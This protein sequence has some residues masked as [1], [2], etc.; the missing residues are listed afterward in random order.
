MD[1]I[2]KIQTIIANL[3]TLI[4]DMKFWGAKRAEAE[5]DYHKC[6][7]KETMKERDKGTAVGIITLTIKGNE[8]VADKRFERDYAE[9]M[10]NATQELINISKLDARMTEAQ[11]QR[12]WG[13]KE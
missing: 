8:E 4:D 5:R 7:S 9:V 1:L 6:L 12:E 11:I 10:Y 2:Q 13:V 3:Y